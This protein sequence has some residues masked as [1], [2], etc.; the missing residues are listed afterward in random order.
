MRLLDYSA[1][2][3]KNIWRRKSRSFL[4]IFAIVIGAI[5][6]VIMLSLVLGAQ[7][8]ATR[9]LESI[10][11]LTLIS[12]SPNPEIQSSGNL[13]DAS[14]G[15]SESEQKLNDTNVA[16]LRTLP[17]V[18][19]AAPL[20]GVWVKNL[21]LEGQ[22][23]KYRANIIA[24]PPSTKV[25]NVPVS[26]GRQLKEGDMDKIVI[27]NELSREFGYA[28]HP[29]DII[30]RK[31]VLYMNEFVDWGTDPPMPPE[32][33]GKEYWDS[34]QKQSHEIT[35]EIIGVV[36]GGPDEGQ[37]YITLGWG[38]RLMTSKRWEYDESKRKVYEEK[39]NQ[40]MQQFN[41]EL[42]S[43]RQKFNEQNQQMSEQLRMNFEQALRNELEQKTNERMISAG[44]NSSSLQVLVK[45]DT[46]M[47]RNG[48]GSILVRV[49][50]TANID[51][52][53]KNIKKLGLGVQT[54]KDM[55]EQIKK[56][57]SLVGLIIGAIGGIVLFV[58]ALGIINNMIMAT[59]ERTREI[60]ILRAC[61]AT[62][63]NIRNMFI[64][65]ASTL[66][67]FGGAIGIIL[68]FGLAKVMNMIGN[69]IAL[70]QSVPISNIISFPLWLI[71]GVIALTTF[72]GTLAGLLPAI[73]AANLDP[74]EG[75]R[76][77]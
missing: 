47:E 33:A 65:E 19:D 51:E 24:Y 12:V 52:A 48:Y 27:G 23:K 13:L 43:Q 10:D 35:A 20:V 34:M 39:R 8:V 25:L 14:Q 70:S 60:G 63:S 17:H 26:F 46:L 16:V 73:R 1:L 38:R 18:V 75:L 74:V 64:F 32:N 76:Y 58:A 44:Y 57:F 77:E 30:G 4:T 59:Y 5:S 49:D 66:G 29:G 15:G 45:Q 2:G 28:S 69:S 56:I 40:I 31:V 41:D 71:A 53:G 11:G 36:T 72:I 22:D 54:A 68:S 21:K 37:N 62:K 61:G 42:N 67:F 7:R 3:I 55:L 6:M 50:N 9:Q